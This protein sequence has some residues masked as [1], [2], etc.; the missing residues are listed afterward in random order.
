MHVSL[1]PH[2]H[3]PCLIFDPPI[4]FGGRHCYNTRCK[5]SFANLMTCRLTTTKQYFRLSA[6]S[7]WNSLI[8]IF[9]SSVRKYYYNDC[10]VQCD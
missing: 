3:Q 7:W 9:V 6:S 5:D 8:Y 4:M 2:A 10:F 1:L